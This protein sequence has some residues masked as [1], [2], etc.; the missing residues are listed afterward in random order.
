M[1][2]TAQYVVSVYVD[3]SRGVWIVRDPDGRLW[4]LTTDHD[5]WRQRQPYDFCGG[6]ELEPVPGHYKSLF[7]LPF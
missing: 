1:E 5:A 4:S 2:A 3:K 7:D 6:A